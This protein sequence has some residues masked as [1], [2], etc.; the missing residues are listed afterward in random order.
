MPYKSRERALEHHRAWHAAN[1]EKTR[2]RNARW[3][4]QNPERRRETQ[5]LWYAADPTKKLASV[6]RWQDANK[7]KVYAN[8]RR[9]Q[10]RKAAAPTVK[11]SVEA[12]AAR[13]AYFGDRCWMC[14]G[15]FQHIDHVKP[16]NKGGAHMLANLRPAC[17]PCNLKKG[18]RWPLDQPTT[19][20]PLVS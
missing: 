4:E 11:F 7:D 15:P 16:L 10:A 5:R 14:G 13:M 1:R 17:A 6:K 9:R 2:E 8:V 12:L 20:M 19:S 3:R 18:D